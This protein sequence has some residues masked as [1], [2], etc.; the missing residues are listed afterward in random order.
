MAVQKTF[1]LL[2]P[3]AVVIAWW[4]PSTAL[5]Y[6]KYVEGIRP[7]VDIIDDSQLSNNGWP[8]G[9]DAMAYF[10]GKRPVYTVPFSDELERYQ[11]KFRMRLVADLSIFGL[12]LYE[13]VGPVTH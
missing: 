2:K 6:G 4:G 8:D 11:K 7:D 5:W 1:P 13:I 9:S 12:S 10:F 3:G